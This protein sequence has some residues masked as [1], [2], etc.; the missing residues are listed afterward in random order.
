MD[1]VGR[2]FDVRTAGIQSACSRPMYMQHEQLL[3]PINGTQREL[4]PGS[5]IPHVLNATCLSRR[6]LEKRFKAALNKTIKDEIERLRIE[7]IQKK[8]R[9]STQSISQIAAELE[10]TDRE[11]FARYYKNQTGQSPMQFR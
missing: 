10:S 5:Q 8:L 11:H 1:G 6:E 2:A 9:N 3:N 7:L 4:I